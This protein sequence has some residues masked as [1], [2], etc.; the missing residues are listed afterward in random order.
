MGNQRRETREK[1]TE[2]PL[3]AA[4]ESVEEE[5]DP[6]FTPQTPSQVARKIESESGDGDGPADAG[7]K[8][9]D[10]EVSGEYERRQE[11]AAAE[12]PLTV[13]E[14]RESRP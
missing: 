11:E 1:K 6:G 10:R 8:E 9:A 4:K 13:E 2:E 7:L 14:P 5:K 12:Q 3:T